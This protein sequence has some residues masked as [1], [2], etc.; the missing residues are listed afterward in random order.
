[1]ALRDSSGN[2]IPLPTKKFDDEQAMESYVKDKDYETSSKPG[3][4][5]GITIYDTADGYSIKLRYDDN[6]FRQTGTTRKQQIPTTR[7][8]I[9]D[10]LKR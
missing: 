3:L 10:K 6:T 2:P 8:E 7:K 1:M 4:C 9:V 5:V